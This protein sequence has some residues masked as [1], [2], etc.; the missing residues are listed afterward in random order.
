[1]EE[2]YGLLCDRSM[3]MK[4]E[5]NVKERITVL[6]PALD[7]NWAVEANAIAKLDG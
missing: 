7:G 3:N 4:I 6:R 2:V 5:R 1:M